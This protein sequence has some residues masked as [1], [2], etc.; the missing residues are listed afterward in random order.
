M[1]LVNKI[2]ALN[3]ILTDMKNKITNQVLNACTESAKNFPN[4]I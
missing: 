1:N 3:N 4:N 2:I